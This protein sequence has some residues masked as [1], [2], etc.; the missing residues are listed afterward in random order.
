MACLL[1]LLT[2]VRWTVKILPMLR[3]PPPVDPPEVDP[4]WLDPPPDALPAKDEDL[5][6]VE[7][8]I[9]AGLMV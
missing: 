1:A 6:G 8:S 5:S 4:P 2:G 7:S 3:E 9:A